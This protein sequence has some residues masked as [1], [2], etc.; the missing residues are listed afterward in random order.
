MK[1]IILLQ[2]DNHNGVVRVLDSIPIRR[3]S[4]HSFKFVISKQTND[5][6]IKIFKKRKQKHYAQI[7]I[8]I[9]GLCTIYVFVRILAKIF[10]L[11]FF[12]D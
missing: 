5:D 6:S 10:Y 8:C 7:C 1:Y 3:I 4:I 11:S 12:I 2:Q 9:L